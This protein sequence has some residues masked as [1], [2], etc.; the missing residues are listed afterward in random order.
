[1]EQLQR[2]RKSQDD[3]EAQ[4]YK[5]PTNGQ[6]LAAGLQPGTW[7]KPLTGGTKNKYQ[8]YVKY[9]II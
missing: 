2:T 7:A 3:T 4:G 6:L 1:M 8:M 9:T 5:H